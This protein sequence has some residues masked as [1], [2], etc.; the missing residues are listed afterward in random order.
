M[1]RSLTVASI[2]GRQI[3]RS[4]GDAER[5]SR[6]SATSRSLSIRCCP[7]TF[8]RAPSMLWRDVRATSNPS[9]ATATAMTVSTITPVRPPKRS[10]EVVIVI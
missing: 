1:R 10:A 8:M 2:L 3:S 5:T 4:A 6:V 9:I 7:A